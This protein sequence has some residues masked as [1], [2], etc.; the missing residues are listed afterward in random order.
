MDFKHEIIRE[1]HICGAN[2]DDKVQFMADCHEVSFM[3]SALCA[4]SR[5]RS[6]F[7]LA[8]RYKKIAGRITSEAPLVPF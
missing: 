8:L 7:L 1:C 5:F 4:Q 2:I 6:V 3:P